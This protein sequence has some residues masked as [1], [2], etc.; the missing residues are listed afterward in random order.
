MLKRNRSLVE[1]CVCP[2]CKHTLEVV[3]ESDLR[4]GVH[5]TTR[6][7]TPQLFRNEALNN[8]VT[9]KRRLNINNF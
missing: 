5:I 3:L 4:Y 2:Y 8:L 9:K 1:H 6:K 7:V